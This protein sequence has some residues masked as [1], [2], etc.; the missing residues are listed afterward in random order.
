MPQPKAT[1][2]ADYRTVTCLCCLFPSLPPLFSCDN[3]MPPVTITPRRGIQVRPRLLDALPKND[4]HIKAPSSVFINTIAPGPD[5]RS[6]AVATVLSRVG[7]ESGVEAREG[8][9]GGGLDSISGRVE[10]VPSLA[11]KLA[12]ALALTLTLALLKTLRT[13]QNSKCGQ[14]KQTRES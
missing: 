12:L 2:Q 5:G 4:G 1:H 13:V 7:G 6:L 14:I 9:D 11:N 8:I 10:E 3:A